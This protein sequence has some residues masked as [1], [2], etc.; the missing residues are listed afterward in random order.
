MNSTKCVRRCTQCSAEF[1]PDPRIG[2][3]QETCGSAECQRK[4]HSKACRRWHAA[5]VEATRSHYQDFVLPFR[6]VQPDYQG[7]WRWGQ[8]LREIREQMGQLGGA[9]LVPLR[10]LISRAQVLAARAVGVVQTGVLAGESMNRA[11]Q[12]VH[13]MVSALE[14]LQASTAELSALGL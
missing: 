14:Q 8:R 2:S 12:A 9:L 5:N 7:R 13:K 4:L 11:M 6:R 3:R 10:G 1:E